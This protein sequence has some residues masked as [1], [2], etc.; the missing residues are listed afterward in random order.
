MVVEEIVAGQLAAYNRR[1]LEAFLGFY[2]DEVRVYAFPSGAEMT[3]RSGSAFRPRYHHLFQSSPSLKAELVSRAVHGN[4]VIDSER[5][6][7]FLNDDSVRH[8]IAIYQVGATKIE[9]VWFVGQ[10]IM[11]P[12]RS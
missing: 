7:G 5:V 9:K 3:D 8:A 2:V 6:S 4:I 10:E 12:A 11:K 1:D